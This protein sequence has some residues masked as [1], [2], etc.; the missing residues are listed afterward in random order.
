MKVIFTTALIEK[1][2]EVRKKEYI[3]SFKS[4][5]NFIN[6][7]NINILECYSS[8]PLFLSE[9]NT[10][11]YFSNTH[12]NTIK[13]KGVLEFQAIDK[14]LIE[15]KLDENYLMKITG[16]YKLLSEY[17]LK[18]FYENS[19]YDFYGKLVDNDT[20]VF[21]GCFI[22]KNLILQEFLSKIDFNLLEN[23]MV[24]IEKSLFDFLKKEN[25]KCFFVDKINIE[26]PIFGVGNVNTYYL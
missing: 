11:I 17:F 9:F 1:M 23:N 25:K 3:D 20:Q 22:I 5:S 16:R 13:N 4:I 24:N 12:Q 6:K 19:D 14:F 18:T 15:N 2:F 26:A 10:F 8:T 7:E 21:T